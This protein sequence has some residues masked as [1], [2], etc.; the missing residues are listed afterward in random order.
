MSFY[1]IKNKQ[2]NEWEVLNTMGIPVAA[3]KKEKHARIWAKCLN[4]EYSIQENQAYY[5]SLVMED[6][7]E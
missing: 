3:F 5:P 6:N 7:L 2:H 1:V 4:G